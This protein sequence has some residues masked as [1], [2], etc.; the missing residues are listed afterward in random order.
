MCIEHE[1]CIKKSVRVIFFICTHSFTMVCCYALTG[2]SRGG[3][4]PLQSGVTTYTKKQALSEKKKLSPNV[5]PAFRYETGREN[6][7]VRV[8]LIRL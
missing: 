5:A 3:E 1:R 4:G 7:V 8:K 6:A 2:R